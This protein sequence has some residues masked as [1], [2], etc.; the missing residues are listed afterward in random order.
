ML[1]PQSSNGETGTPVLRAACDP[2]DY[3]KSFSLML[4]DRRYG[5]DLQIS[6]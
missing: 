5:Q 3:F 4:K 2:K 1:D 6:S